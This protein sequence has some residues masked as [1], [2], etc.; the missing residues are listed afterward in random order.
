MKKLHF[1]LSFLLCLL[2]GTNYIGAQKKPEAVKEGDVKEVLLCDFETEGSPKDKNPLNWPDGTA[3]PNSKVLG[4]R[5]YFSERSKFTLK[6]TPYSPIQIPG[7]VKDLKIWVSGRNVPNTLYAVL[8]DAHGQIKRIPFQDES[9]SSYLTF[10]GWR[11]LKAIVPD[12]VRQKEYIYSREP[13]ICLIGLELD[14]YSYTT[15][16]GKEYYMYL[17]DLTAD[18]DTY[19]QYVC[20]EDDIPDNWW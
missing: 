1:I 19:T 12:C 15:E 18:T 6:L 2:L 14:F 7:I 11:Q 9:G 3:N 4:V 17:D 8:R 5:A 20:S 13:F 16:H 10:T